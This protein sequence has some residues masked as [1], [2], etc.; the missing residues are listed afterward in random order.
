MPFSGKYAKQSFNNFFLL[1]SLVSN[2]P[3]LFIPAPLPPPGVLPLHR[4]KLTHQKFPGVLQVFHGREGCSS[5]S[6]QTHTT[7]P[8]I[9]LVRLVI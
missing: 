6:V 2:S 3:P 9:K 1:P 8:G 5:Y 7:S 4:L